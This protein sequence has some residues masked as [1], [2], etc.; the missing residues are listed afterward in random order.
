[1]KE[2]LGG[3]FI[4]CFSLVHFMIKLVEKLNQSLEEGLN[5]QHNDKW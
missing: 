3:L 5:P 2:S 4:T 1:M